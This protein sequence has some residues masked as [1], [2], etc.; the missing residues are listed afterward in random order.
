MGEACNTSEGEERFIQGFGGE[1]GGRTHLKDQ[2]V[3][4]RI[5]LK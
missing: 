2:G 5:I 4:G 3:D 1:P